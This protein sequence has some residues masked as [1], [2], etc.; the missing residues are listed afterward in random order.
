M[1]KYLW[2]VLVLSGLQI[3]A[4]AQDYIG[5]DSI[6]SS[7]PLFSYDDQERWKHGYLKEMPYYEGFHSFRPYNYHHVFSQSQTSAGWGMPPVM[8]YSQQFWHRYEH[9]TNL[10]GREFSS[11]YTPSMQPTFARQ[12]SPYM[13]YPAV[14]PQFTQQPVMPVQTLPVMPVQ[15][16]PAV[17][18]ARQGWGAQP[19]VPLAAPSPMMQYLSNGP[20]LP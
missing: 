13:P 15:Y 6:G 11:T 5:P 7:E 12:M 9:M 20:T 4:Q 18:A 14:E 16:E 17:D 19:S 2:L 10:T 8:P 3:E 1:K